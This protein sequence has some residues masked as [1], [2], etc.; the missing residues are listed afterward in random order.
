MVRTI[1]EQACWTL[2]AVPDT[3]RQLRANVAAFASAAGAPPELQDIIALAVSETV[4]NAIVHAYPGARESGTVRVRCWVSEGQLVVE[5]A[6]DGVGMTRRDD[7]PGIGHGLAMVGAVAE[8]LE[9]APGRDG[10]GTAVTMMFAAGTIPQ[11]VPGL[12]PLCRLALDSV[13]DVACV[14]LVR[15][16]VLRRVAGE[17]AGDD[18]LTAWL[19][20]ATP[21]AK[22]GTATWAALREGGPH[23]V[24]HDPAVPR[25]PGGVG[26]ILGLEW[27]VAVP[28]EGPDGAPAA[29]WGLGGRAGGSPAPAAAILD[30]LGDAA[31]GDLADAT[32][33]AALRARLDAP[34]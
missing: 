29:L 30:A 25:S 14:D 26:E 10:H 31:R 16:G 1:D 11:P 17:V 18:G 2:P 21:P 20:N 13:A 9:I 19:R 23:L 24:V 32:Q 22:P 27:W 6:D 7:S 15:G 4:T 33:R 5:V 3:V 28:L 34:D 12:E 8:A